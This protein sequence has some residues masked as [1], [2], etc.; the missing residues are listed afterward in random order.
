VIHPCTTAL[1]VRGGRDTLEDDPSER[2]FPRRT[3]GFL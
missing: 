2:R 3:I 1:Y